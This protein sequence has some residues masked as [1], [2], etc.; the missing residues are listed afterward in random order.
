MTDEFDRAWQFLEPSA[1]RD[2]EHTKESVK[3]ALDRGCRKLWV[4]DE[5]AVIAERVT[6]PSGL[7]VGSVWLAG[8]ML[9]P[10]LKLL[11]TVED[12]MRSNGAVEAR[13]NGRRGWLPVTGY[14]EFRVAIRKDLHV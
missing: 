12:W 5:Y 9:Q 6:F 2:G 8:G 4:T 10:M 1:I 11:P 7:A 14:K 13:V 3:L